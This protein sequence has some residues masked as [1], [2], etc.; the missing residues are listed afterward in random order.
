MKFVYM[1]ITVYVYKLVKHIIKQ[2]VLFE[3]FLVL[4][5]DDALN[6]FHDKV[7]TDN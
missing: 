6:Q 7:R 4:S 3:T 5:N 1:Y 2:T